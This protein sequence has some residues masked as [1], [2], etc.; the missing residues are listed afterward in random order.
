MTSPADASPVSQ[1]GAARYWVEQ[2]PA[3]T[4]FRAAAVPGPKHI[5]HNTLS[6]L[7][8]ADLPIIGRVA[9][10]I[11]WRQPPPASRL[12]GRVPIFT[13][14]ADSVLAPSGS[15]YADFCALARLGWSTQWPYRTTIA[16]PYRN[17]TPPTGCRPGPPVRFAERSNVRRRKLNWN[18]A[19]LLEA[20]RYSSSADYHNWD[21]AM[22]LLTE[23]NGWMKQGEPIRKEVIMWAAETETTDR[24]PLRLENRQAFDAVVSGLAADLP[25]RLAPR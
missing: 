11:Y 10:S 18:E 25:D 14:G 16:V 9:H 12:Y 6:R 23:A 1:S 3:G 2:L 19:T 21:H 20:A 24:G 7:L 4:W 5:A 8:A 17:L 22:W 15:G 13:H